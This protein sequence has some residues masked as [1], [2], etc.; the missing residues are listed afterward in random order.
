MSKPR[1]LR[2]GKFDPVNAAVAR[3]VRRGGEASRVRQ[4]AADQDIDAVMRSSAPLRL[5]GNQPKRSA[6]GPSTGAMPRPHPPAPH[7]PA[8]PARAAGHG[9]LIAAGAAGAA[10]LGGAGYL[11]HRHRRNAVRKL[12]DP[13]TD[14]VVEFGKSVHQLPA[15]AGAKSTG[16]RVTPRRVPGLPVASSRSV[17]AL[18]P[19]GRHVSHANQLKRV[20]SGRKTGPSTAVW[21]HS[22]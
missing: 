14:S 8:T 22:G 5:D 17:G 16:L 9:R 19:T 15:S 2:Q 6:I 20:G 1:K 13:F 11:A 21:H 10:V 18:V 3:S 12:Y 4:A 7:T